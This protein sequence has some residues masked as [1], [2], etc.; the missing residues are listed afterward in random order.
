MEELHVVNNNRHNTVMIA[1]PGFTDLG[2]IEEDDNV[3]VLMEMMG[4]AEK[5]V[6]NYVEGTVERDCE[7]DVVFTGIVRKNVTRNHL[8]HHESEE[9]SKMED[10]CAVEGSEETTLMTEN[11]GNIDV[12]KEDDDDGKIAKC[13]LVLMDL[14][15]NSLEKFSQG[16][17]NLKVQYC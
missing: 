7:D 16:K 10:E 15:T 8:H 9:D 5:N 3:I 14:E 6:E 12:E 13:S 4:D 1:E 11:E 17:G 2:N